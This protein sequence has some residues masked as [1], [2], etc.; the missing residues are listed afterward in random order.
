MSHIEAKRAGPDAI[1]AC[2]AVFV[3]VWFALQSV[4][5]V[6]SH[7]PRVVRESFSL[8]LDVYLL[9]IHD[10]VAMM[11][12]TTQHDMLIF[13][14]VFRSRMLLLFLLLC[15]LLWRNCSSN[16]KHMQT[17]YTH[18]QANFVVASISLPL[19]VCVDLPHSVTHP[20][21]FFFECLELHFHLTKQNSPQPTLQ[22]TP[23]H[24][25]IP[26][27]QCINPFNTFCRCRCLCCCSSLTRDMRLTNRA[28][29]RPVTSQQQHIVIIFVY[30]DFDLC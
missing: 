6:T 25:T 9:L 21:C 7:V 27:S 23:P 19:C 13:K 22:L 16:V 11:F 1:Y 20:P 26:G 8:P 4:S 28:C 2:R 14:I 18:T 5:S 12:D 17:S 15:Y 24:L 29:R 10:D 30:F 3:L